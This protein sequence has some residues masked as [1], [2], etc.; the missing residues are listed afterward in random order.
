MLDGCWISGFA[1]CWTRFSIWPRQALLA[2]EP[3]AC[4]ARPDPH[5]GSL[6]LAA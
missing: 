3:E 6:A 1:A 4:R 2:R 5:A